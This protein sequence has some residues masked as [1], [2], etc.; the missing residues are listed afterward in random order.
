MLNNT[1][2]KGPVASSASGTVGSSS[3]MARGIGLAKLNDSMADKRFNVNMFVAR[4][5]VRNQQAFGS[6]IIETEFG[7]LTMNGITVK[8]NIQKNVE[9]TQMP[10]KAY[11]NKREGGTW[12][13]FTNEHGE[14]WQPVGALNY[15]KFF[16]NDA[17]GIVSK[18]FYEAFRLCS[19]CSNCVDVDKSVVDRIVNRIA[20]IVL[21][22]EE[23]TEEEVKEKEKLDSQLASMNKTCYLDKDEDEVE[24]STVRAEGEHGEVS[25]SCSHYSHQV[26]DDSK[27]SISSAAKLFN[28]SADVKIE[29]ESD[30][31]EEELF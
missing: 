5:P 26:M 8:K 29:T 22:G 13:V 19:T 21:K 12:N 3:T 4:S 25:I 11:P 31:T 27:A 7:P 20:E 18:L 15:T 14:V 6:I 23:A 1:S 10:F 30:E 9:S 24:W 2:W 28:M 16:D 17:A